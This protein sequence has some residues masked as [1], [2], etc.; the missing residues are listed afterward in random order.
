MTGTGHALEARDP[1]DRAAWV[2]AWER[3]GREP[4]AH[5]AYVELFCREPGERAVCVVHRAPS[6]E[7]ILPFVV[8]PVPARAG[9]SAWDAVS[10][11]GYGGPWPS[12]P[13]SDGTVW[14]EAL[15]WMREAG[16]VSFFGRVGLFSP[17]PAS[18]DVAR[19][20]RHVSDN[21]VVDLTRTA[22]EQWMHYEHK[23]RKNVKKAQRAGLEVE[24]RPWFTDLAE[25]TDLYHGTMRRREAASFYYFDSAFFSALHDAMPDNVVAAEVRSPDGRLVSAELVLAGDTHLY[26]FLGG[27]RADAFRW[28]PNDLLKHAVIEYGRATGRRG[29]VLGGGYGPEDGILRYKSSFDPTG[30]HPFRTLR[31]VLDPAAYAALSRDDAAGDYFPAYR[32]SPAPPAV[33]DAN[34][35]RTDTHGVTS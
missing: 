33:T 35:D 12:A 22:D 18:Q 32:R 14:E 31:A 3:C 10:P 19:D 28:A 6:S 9:A 15:R 21:V 4:F 23:V 2:D 30:R 27:T 29:F 25:F 13:T 8:R 20:V 16:L 7:A 34:D 5:P 11:Y 24:V 1:G 17:L 26:S